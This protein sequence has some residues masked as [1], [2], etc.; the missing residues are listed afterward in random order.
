MI[1]H[2]TYNIFETNRVAWK[3]RI[4]LRQQQMTPSPS[5]DDDYHAET[6]I[7]QQEAPESPHHHFK[8]KTENSVI[9]KHQRRQQR[10]LKHLH[11]QNSPDEGIDV[12][13]VLHHRAWS[14][15]KEEADD[16]AWRHSL[17]SRPKMEQNSVV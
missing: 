1:G 7:Q 10:K 9:T 15:V 12:P 4:N 14:A 3:V 11:L 8:P 2:I 6:S 16:G 13:A 5:F 17:R